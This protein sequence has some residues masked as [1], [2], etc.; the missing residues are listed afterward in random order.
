MAAHDSEHEVERRAGERRVDPMG[1]AAAEAALL[2]LGQQA[3]A[4]GV[5]RAQMIYLEHHR[6]SELARLKRMS[7][8]KSDDKRE[9]WARDHPDYRL[10]LEAQWEAIRV[11]ETMA[12][13]KAQAEA[14]ISAWQTRNANVRSAGNFR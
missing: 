3:E 11:Y 5:A 7:T 2:F 9:A 6:K 1:D 8:E 4:A 14:T 13:K 10:V 12:W